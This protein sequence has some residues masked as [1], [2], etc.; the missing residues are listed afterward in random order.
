MLV[1]VPAR[2]SSE[3]MAVMP[4]TP[5]VGFFGYFLVRLQESSS[6]KRL[7]GDVEII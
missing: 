3:V 4:L 1:I 7:K 2:R 5:P 6:S